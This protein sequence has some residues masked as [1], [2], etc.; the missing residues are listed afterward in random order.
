[1]THELNAEYTLHHAAETFSFKPW[2]VKST[3]RHGYGNSVAIQL[4]S[5]STWVTQSF[6]IPHPSKG[7]LSIVFSASDSSPQMIEL[8]TARMIWEIL[9]AKGWRQ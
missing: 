1:M 3:R 2:S 5:R 6:G 4:H 7:L 8:D 9:V